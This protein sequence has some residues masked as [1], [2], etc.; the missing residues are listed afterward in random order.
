MHIKWNT[1]TWYSKLAAV[2]VF[3]GTFLI[4]FNLGI[5]YEQVHVEN[6]LLEAPSIPGG[7]AG[8]RCGGFIRNAPTCA[9]GYHCQLIVSRPDTGGVCVKD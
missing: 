2:V 5:L 4:A 9:G 1:V 8:A 7:T 3:L 6:A